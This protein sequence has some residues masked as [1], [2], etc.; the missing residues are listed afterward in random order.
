MAN[1]FPDMKGT[2][3]SFFTLKSRR[4]KADNKGPL[5]VT[6]SV[7]NPDDAQTPGASIINPP[8]DTGSEIPVGVDQSC[9]V[10][11]AVNL[12]DEERALSSKAPSQCQSILGDLSEDDEGNQSRDIQPDSPAAMQTPVPFDSQ[13]G[14]PTGSNGSPRI[15]YDFAIDIWDQAYDELKASQNDMVLLYESI[16]CSRLGSDFGITGLISIID[17]NHEIRK[18]QMYVCMNAW[19]ESM[20]SLRVSKRR[21]FERHFGIPEPPFSD[22]SVSLSESDNS[23]TFN[24]RLRAF[25]EG[26]REDTERNPEAFLAWMA[27][28]CALVTVSCT[29]R[30]SRGNGF[31]WIVLTQISRLCRYQA[32]K[33]AV[34]TKA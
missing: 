2:F 23:N 26:L 29:L 16:I 31:P 13:I 18:H 28:I 9:T 34:S 4:K 24:Q 12:V 32:M 14:V 20:N 21:S 11:S 5:K 17:D 15:E 6:T 3:S 7:E 8:L 27:V 10:P 33:F 30:I 22:S 19:L 25:V 1:K